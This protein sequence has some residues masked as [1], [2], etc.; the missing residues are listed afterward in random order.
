MKKK[1]I[2]VNFKRDAKSDAEKEHQRALEKARIVYEEWKEEF[3][4]HRRHPNELPDCLNDLAS[5]IEKA[6]PDPDLRKYITNVL[7]D[8]LLAKAHM[9]G[10][11]LL[12]TVE[13]VVDCP[14]K[15]T[16]EGKET[17]CGWGG[18]GRP[19]QKMWD[20]KAV[21]MTCPQCGSLLKQ[22]DGDMMLKSEAVKLKPKKPKAL[23]PGPSQS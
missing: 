17:P 13:I 14:N 8:P 5:R 15:I 20:A 7:I 22:E 6:V 16:I 11:Q 9:A 23:P 21:A 4:N 2:K 18:V 19:S 10:I 12:G 1:P 3:I